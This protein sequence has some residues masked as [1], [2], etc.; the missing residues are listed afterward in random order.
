MSDFHSDDYGLKNTVDVKLRELVSKGKLQGISVLAT[1]VG[2]GS[3]EE[4]KEILGSRRSSNDKIEIS[5]HFNL[6]EGMPLSPPNTVKNLVNSEGALYPL[7]VFF[8]HL[9]ARKITKDEIKR[10]LEAQIARLEDSEV[11]LTMIDSHQHTHALSPVAEIVCESAEQRGLKI[12]SFGSVCHFT[13]A[14][15]LKY[16]LLRIMAFISYFAAYGRPGMP[17]TWQDGHPVA[18]M[19]WE[20]KELNVKDYAKEDISFVIHPYLPYDTNRSYEELIK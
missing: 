12:R 4:L 14:S 15:R 9:I 3:M 13:L 19:S 20:G 18:I 1:M 5:L 11:R 17:A 8:L 16:A 2:Q 7:V 6:I 10:E